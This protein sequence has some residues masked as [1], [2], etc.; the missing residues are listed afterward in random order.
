MGFAIKCPLQLN[1]SNNMGLATH[2]WLI[3]YVF[4]D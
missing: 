4:L 1:G 3:A 2:E